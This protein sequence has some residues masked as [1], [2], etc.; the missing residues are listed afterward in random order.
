MQFEDTQLVALCLKGD[1]AAF[2]RLVEKY[3]GA[4]YATAYYYVGRYGAAEDIAQEAFFQAYRSLRQ[5]NDA[6]RFGP[7]LR[8]IACR[9]A[10]NWLRKNGKRLTTE[11]PLPFRRTVSIEDLREG[12]GLKLERAELYERVQKAVNELP[13]RYRLPVVLRYLQELSYDEIGAFTG[14]SRD[15]VRGILQRAGRQ[16]R[17]MLES[18]DSNREGSQNW[19]RARE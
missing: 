19:H 10:A 8:E 13:E 14:D 7:W 2:G 17:D 5:L 4:V 15:E 18:P 16:L 12:P 6:S 11:T 9:T 1:T 3:Q